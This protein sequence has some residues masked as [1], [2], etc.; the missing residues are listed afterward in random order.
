MS[1]V[2]CPQSMTQAKTS[3]VDPGAPKPED[4]LL[5][6]KEFLVLSP[7]RVKGSSC[8]VW[9]ARIEVEPSVSL[10]LRQLHQGP[11][12]L[13][14]NRD[15]KDN[16]HS[17]TR[18]HLSRQAPFLAVTHISFWPHTS[19]IMQML[20][21]CLLGKRG[22]LGIKKKKRTSRTPMVAFPAQNKRK[23][24]SGYMRASMGAFVP[25]RNK[26]LRSVPCLLIPLLSSFGLILPG[27]MQMSLP[28]SPTHS[29]QF[30]PPKLPEYIY[31][32]VRAL[33]T[34][35]YF[36]ARLSPLLWIFKGRDLGFLLFISWASST[37]AGTQQVF[38]E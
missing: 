10:C 26:C 16:H 29:Q 33:L 15:L 13:A 12:M 30:L 9:V 20:L 25:R 7:E 24:K 14:S 27:S 2:F 6:P 8:Y 37:E 23:K 28:P 3:S 5:L 31:C 4:W 38:Y 1:S 22:Q 17:N 19:P 21:Q 18:S 36:F 34:C 32:S 35:F 11:W